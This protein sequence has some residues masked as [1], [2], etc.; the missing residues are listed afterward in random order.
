MVFRPVCRFHI[1]SQLDD[2][3]LPTRRRLYGYMCQKYT[4]NFA[5]VNAEVN[6][7][8]AV[9]SDS[10]LKTQG[11]AQVDKHWHGRC[12]FSV[13]R[14]AIRHC[15]NGGEGRKEKRTN[16]SKE[17]AIMLSLA[18]KLKSL[19]I[20]VAGA[21]GLCFVTACEPP[22]AEPGGQMPPPEEE[23]QQQEEPEESEAE[24]EAEPEAETEEEE[25]QEMDW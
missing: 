1:R 2:A 12:L 4:A 24:P 7:K 21:A 23:E 25:Q 3:G 16:K 18:E 22:P 20:P 19:L 14:L 5:D 10:R 17:L 11:F 6:A 8:I 9:S 15:R 13:I